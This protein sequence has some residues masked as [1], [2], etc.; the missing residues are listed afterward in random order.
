MCVK[1]WSFFCVLQTNKKQEIQITAAKW[2]PNLYAMKRWRFIQKQ[3]RSNPFVFMANM[4]SDHGDTNDIFTKQHYILRSKK[5][6][7]KLA[8]RIV[9]VSFFFWELFS[10]NL[11]PSLKYAQSHTNTM[12]HTWHTI[13]WTPKSVRKQKIFKD[14]CYLILSYLTLLFAI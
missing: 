9:F 12:L 8:K 10:K 2:K 14:T 4:A 6:P 5:I 13:H 11:L 7:T 3:K 1:K